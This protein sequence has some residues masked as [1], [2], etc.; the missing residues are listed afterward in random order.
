[1]KRIKFT[2]PVEVRLLWERDLNKL[3][4]K[5]TERVYTTTTLRSKT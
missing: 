1:M 4:Y 2:C 5:I 3:V